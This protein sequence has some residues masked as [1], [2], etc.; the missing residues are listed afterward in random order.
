MNNLFIYFFSF[1]LQWK[2]IY[3]NSSCID[4]KHKT[5]LF[6]PHFIKTNKC[7]VQTIFMKFAYPDYIMSTFILS[8][9]IYF[10]IHYI[11]YIIF[12]FIFIIYYYYINYYIH[13]IM[14]YISYLNHS[15]DRRVAWVYTILTHYQIYAAFAKNSYWIICYCNSFFKIEHFIAHNY[16]IP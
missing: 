12:R 13:Q 9:S 1:I 5:I 14:H 3:F 11:L 16:E 2:I 10:Y 8:L 4:V 6:I 7:N 15:V